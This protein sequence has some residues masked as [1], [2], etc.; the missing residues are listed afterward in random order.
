MTVYDSVDAINPPFSTISPVSN[1]D[2]FT[3][4]SQLTALVIQKYASLDADET[5]EDFYYEDP[6][7]SPDQHLLLSRD[8]AHRAKFTELIDKCHFERLET[9]LESDQEIDTPC[10]TNQP[11][12]PPVHKTDE[13]IDHLIIHNTETT[14]TL[15]QIR[16]KKSLKNL[17][18]RLWKSFRGQEHSSGS[19]TPQSTV[20]DGE[21]VDSIC[22]TP[23]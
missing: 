15:D 5:T 4:Y 1:E 20:S 19:R 16:P 11:I 2:I 17:A 23:A 14:I 22:S 7:M 8:D 12:L 3:I 21:E 6:P 9:I 13:F 10:A 18:I